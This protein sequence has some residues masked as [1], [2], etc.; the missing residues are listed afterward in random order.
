MEIIPARQTQVKLLP[1]C[2]SFASTQLAL[3]WQGLLW[4]A[5]N[6]SQ[7]VPTYWSSQLQEKVA[8][9]TNVSHMLPESSKMYALALQCNSKFKGTASFYNYASTEY[10]HRITYILIR[11]QSELREKLYVFPDILISNICFSHSFFL[12]IFIPTIFNLIQ[13][14]S[15]KENCILSRNEVLLTGHEKWQCCW[16][17]H[18][19][20]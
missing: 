10:F 6:S 15:G 18:I 5:S 9:N 1:S 20:L 2:F 11:L 12:L 4:Q 8:W 16:S 3:F 19:V 13:N 17:R 14:R 7:K